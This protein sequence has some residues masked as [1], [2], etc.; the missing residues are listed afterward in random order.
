MKAVGAALLATLVLLATGT[1]AA[2]A[3]RPSLRPVS[4]VGVGVGLTIRGVGWVPGERVSLT[5]LA[6]GGK[7]IRHAVA[8]AAGTFAVSFGYV[9]PRCSAWQVR[10]IGT[11][12][13]T[14]WLRRPRIDC[15][16]QA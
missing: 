13:G 9:P 7:R 6:P 4:G 3:T 11:K 8:T 12:S 14:V 5:L 1:V 16:P 15:A 2:S 10:A